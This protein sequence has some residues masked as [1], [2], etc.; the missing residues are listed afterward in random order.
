MIIGLLWDGWLSPGLKLREK[1]CFQGLRILPVEKSDPAY[2]RFRGTND[3]GRRG[4]V[5]FKPGVSHRYGGDGLSDGAAVSGNIRELV[6][7]TRYVCDLIDLE[8]VDEVLQERLD[9]IQQG[10]WAVGPEGEC[11]DL[12]LPSV[13]MLE[14]SGTDL[15]QYGHRIFIA[16]AVSDKVFQFL[17][18]QKQ[19]VELIVRDFTRVFSAP[20]SFYAF[21]RKGGRVQ[22]L[23]RSRL[24]AVTINP[25]S[26]GGLLLDSLRLQQ[27]LE[28]SLQIPVYDVKKIEKVGKNR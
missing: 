25:Q 3:L 10:V 12:K 27:A 8:E 9:A 22:V 6:R 26:P 17:R 24:L 1:Y 16:G 28:E 14:K 20:E 19:T 21:L 4:F 5:P 11:I 2:E 15:L 18:V 23:H 13:F 7:R